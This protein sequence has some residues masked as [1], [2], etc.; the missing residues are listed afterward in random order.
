MAEN[1]AIEW[2]DH[3]FNP[4]EGCQKVAPE[5]DNCY[6]EA[7]DKR[8]TGGKHWGPDAPRRRT[9]FAS[10]LHPIM[11]NKRAVAEGIR[12][13]VFCAS[14]ADVFD[15]AVDPRWRIDLFELIRLTPNLDWL[16]LTK[17]PQNMRG[18]LPY[19]W[20]NGWPNVWLGTSAGSQKTANTN[21]PHLLATP[22]AVRFVS[23]EPLL[24][25]VDL[26]ACPRDDA[27]LGYLPDETGDR[28][29]IDWVI[30]GGESGPGARPMHPDWARSLRD[31]CQAAGVAFF[32]KQW[33]EYETH[34]D[35]PNDDPDWRRFDTVAR[36][37]PKGRWL[38]M[39]GGVGFHGERLVRVSP[40]GKARAGRLL[41]GRTWDEFPKGSDA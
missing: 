4:W 36:G 18:M 28:S 6:A 15:N 5:C 14:L 37:D 13:R 12:Y 23:C 16:L 21:I 30:C 33:G 31:Q 26:T 19:D 3:T 7:R 10:W 22:A 20:G 40:V 34:Y 17:R 8:F 29:A 38:N 2:C 41:D 32:F 25:P 11:W 35:R 27:L 1:S 39:E 24:G 9:T